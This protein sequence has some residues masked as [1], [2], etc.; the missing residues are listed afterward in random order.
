[1]LA[2]LGAASLLGL[3]AGVSFVLHHQATPSQPRD[4]ASCVA[5]VRAV[6]PAVTGWHGKGATGSWPP[7]LAAVTRPDATGTIYLPRIPTNKHYIITLDP[8]SGVVRVN[9]R[10]F[11]NDTVCDQVSSAG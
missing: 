9:G 4:Q 11:V 6:D 7:D 2:V 3:V 8:N 1:V 5:D 10:E